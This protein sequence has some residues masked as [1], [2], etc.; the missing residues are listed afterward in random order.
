MTDNEITLRVR[1]RAKTDFADS[2]MHSSLFSVLAA[3]LQFYGG[4]KSNRVSIEVDGQQMSAQQL[5]E[6]AKVRQNE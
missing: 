5:V 3:W 2:N 6:L 1:I 4:F